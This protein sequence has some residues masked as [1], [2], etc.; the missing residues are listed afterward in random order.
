MKQSAITQGHRYTDGRSVRWVTRVWR[1]GFP[2]PPF[3]R[4]PVLVLH[5]RIDER[6]ICREQGY[7]T[8]ATFARWAR[9]E[10][11]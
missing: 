5:T 9:E 1:G 7:C 3:I 10:V 8:L 6:G 4:P 11:V 2:E